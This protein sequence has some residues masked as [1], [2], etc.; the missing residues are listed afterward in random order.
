MGQIEIFNS[1][2]GIEDCNLA[3]NLKLKDD[4]F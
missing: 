3:D 1:W 2:P 4:T